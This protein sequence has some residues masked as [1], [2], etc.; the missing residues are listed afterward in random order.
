MLSNGY[1]FDIRYD[2]TL[3]LQPCCIFNDYT[4]VSDIKDLTKWRK[5]LNS[6][7]STKSSLCSEC[8][9]F[10]NQGIRKSWRDHSFTIVPDDAELGDA[11]YLEVQFDKTC[12]GGCIMCGPYYSS[13]WANEVKQ[14]QRDK[15]DH[16]QTILEIV[17]LSK[18]RKILFLGGEPLLS[19]TDLRLLAE[20][21]N[22][23]IVDI[24][25]TTNG[26]VYPSAERLEL[27][28]SFKSVM[29]NFSIDGTDEI[30]EY[31]RYP[32]K[33]NTVENNMFRM[34]DE[35]PSNVK[36][37]LNHTVNILNLWYYDKFNAWY[38][39]NFKTDRHGAEI[40]CTFSPATGILTA[41]SATPKFQQRLE[42]KYAGVDQR[43]INIIKDTNLK[44]D[45]ML[46][47]L[48]ELDQRRSTNWKN[49]FPDIVDC[50]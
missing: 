42:Q 23:S 16:L 40:I 49:L 32:L 2:N 39:N 13:F 35:L 30:F 34:R 20:V 24:Q 47:Y 11:S 38:Q 44:P 10:K 15:T 1:K 45:A 7:D 43:V 3:T 41:Y 48:S 9:F 27:W 17:D 50:F 36:I 22:P 19:D 14:Y 18:T 29:L 26:S 46:K 28:K 33:W 6:I 21:P 37:K 4:K 25:Y 31:V 8:N 5:K 12:N